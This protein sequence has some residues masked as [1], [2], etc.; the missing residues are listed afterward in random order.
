MPC[1]SIP[2]RC[3]YHSPVPPKPHPH[4]ALLSPGLPPFTVNPPSQLPAYQPIPGEQP[5][6]T[7]QDGQFCPTSQPAWSAYREPTFGHG[8]FHLLEGVY[9][10]PCRIC[11]CM[12]SHALATTMEAPAQQ[13]SRQA[14]C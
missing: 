10:P 13:P 2:R 1:T 5:V 4:R 7:L 12:C 8:A 14:P 6:I 3:A 11:S 9:V